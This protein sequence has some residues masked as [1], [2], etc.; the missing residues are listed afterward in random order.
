[1]IALLDTHSF[2]WAVI[3]P[4]K[5]SPAVRKTIADPANEIYLSTVSLWEIS[6]KFALGSSN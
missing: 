3:E 4:R 6:L 1:M 5:L 2:L